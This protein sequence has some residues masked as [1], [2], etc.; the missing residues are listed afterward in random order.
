MASRAYTEEEIRDQFL[1]HVRTLSRYW[2]GLDGSNVEEDR[3]TEDRLDGLAFSILAAIDG[4]STWLP[5]F[6]LIPNPHPDDKAYHKER[7]ENYYPDDVDIAGG[8]H[9]L[10]HTV[11]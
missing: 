4:S 2:A 11:L 1:R 3:S 9:E 7:D 10:W 6:K 8:L 5:G